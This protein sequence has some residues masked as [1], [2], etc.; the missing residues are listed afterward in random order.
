MDDNKKPESDS[1]V[2]TLLKKLEANSVLMTVLVV[3]LIS[4]GGIV[5]IVPLYTVQGQVITIDAVKPYRPLELEG[6]DIYI[7]EGCY[8]CHSQAVRPFRDETER[9]GPYSKAGEYVYDRPFQFGSKRTGPDLHREG[10]ANKD[11]WHYLHFRNPR[12][13]SPGSIMPNYPWLYSTKLDTSSTVKKLEVLRSLGTPY[14][15][16]DISQ[17]L[18]KV[19]RDAKR[20]AERISRDLGEEV[21][22]DTEV[23]AL[24]AYMQKLG[25]DI[26]WR[27]K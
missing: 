7:R 11:S 15:E 6:R 18:V 16:D 25:K 26:K 12:D 21:E 2:M 5:E 19:E 20:I 4:I 14:D 3:I 9:Y 13:T 22:P 10:G 8:T 27:D 1:W 23:I 17:A 24:I